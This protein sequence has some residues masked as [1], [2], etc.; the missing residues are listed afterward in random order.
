MALVEGLSE[1]ITYIL[2]KMVATVVLG[3]FH[4]RDS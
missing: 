1:V 4:S 2:T 3:A